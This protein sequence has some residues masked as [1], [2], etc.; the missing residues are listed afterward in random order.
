MILLMFFYIFF[1]LGSLKAEKQLTPS[2]ANVSENIWDAVIQTCDVQGAGT[3]ATVYLKV[4]YEKDH[5]DQI[6]PLDN[7]GKNDFERGERSHFKLFLMQDDII[8]LGLFWWPGFTINEQW[9]VEWVLLLNSNKGKCYEGIFHK[10]ILHYKNPPTYATRFH[11]LDYSDCINPAPE[12]AK[13]YHF[14]RLLDDDK[15]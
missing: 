12:Y 13:R 3:D 4:Y 2:L 9:C 5:A 15:K 6:F 10:W 11:R 14:L 7:P 8:N 1:P